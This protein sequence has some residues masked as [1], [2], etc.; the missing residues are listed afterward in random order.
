MHNTSEN[1]RTNV[2]VSQYTPDWNDLAWSTLRNCHGEIGNSPG[3][4][5]AIAGCFRFL[6]RHAN[7][8][9]TQY[10]NPQSVITAPSP[11]RAFIRKARQAQRAWLKT[12]KTVLAT[13]GCLKREIKRRLPEIRQL[14]FTGV[15]LINGKH[16][17]PQ[18][19]PAAEPLPSVGGLVGQQFGRLTVVRRVP[20]GQWLCNCA[21]GGHNTVRTKH[22]LRGNI[23]SCGCL[24]AE[25]EARQRGRRV[26]RAWVQAGK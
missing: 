12:L 4:D 23:R 20:G 19:W 15:M 18:Q 26:N 14:Q 9:G 17:H 24:K 7:Q 1:R 11:S 16:V 21:C 22:L 10:M 2:R 8:L 3:S 5:E 13:S 25:V 6:M